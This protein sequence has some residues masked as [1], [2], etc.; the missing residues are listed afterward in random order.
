MGNQV[1][2]GLCCDGDNSRE[3]KQVRQVAPAPKAAFE[4]RTL[5]QHSQSRINGKLLQPFASSLANDRGNAARVSSLQQQIAA[6]SRPL[7]IR[8]ER[9]GP[10]VSPRPKN[11]GS[12]NSSPANFAGFTAPSFKPPAIGLRKKAAFSHSPD[13]P[14]SPSPRGRIR[15]SGGNEANVSPDRRSGRAKS[16]HASGGLYEDNIENRMGVQKSSTRGKQDTPVVTRDY[17]L[18]A[19]AERSGNSQWTALV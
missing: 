19:Q 7:P 2:G 14:F 11:A 3:I 16:D 1:G 18:C 4:T 8:E 5:Q 15:S 17:N 9:Q 13:S 12:E 10:L 6:D